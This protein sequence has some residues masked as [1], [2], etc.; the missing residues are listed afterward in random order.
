[1]LTFM[2]VGDLIPEVTKNLI[3]DILARL[4]DLDTNQSNLLG[5]HNESINNFIASKGNFDNRITTLEMKSGDLS[6][7]LQIERQNINHMKSRLSHLDETVQRTTRSHRRTIVNDVPRN[8]AG[9][10]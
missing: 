6:K 3:Q 9:T 4:K 5:M 7:N 1:M 10:I 8:T 2:F